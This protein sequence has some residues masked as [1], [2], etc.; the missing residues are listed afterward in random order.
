MGKTIAVSNQKGGVGKT[1]TCINLAA[2]IA[3]KG[4]K[5][6]LCDIDPQ[7][8]ATT[9]LGIEKGSLK[10]SM[11]N[12]LLGDAA[13]KDAIVP[14]A[15]ENLFILPS[16]TDLAGV[17]VELVSVRGRDKKL[18]EALESVKNAYDY[19]FI[20]CPPAIGILTVNGLT[21]CNSVLVPIQSEFFALEGVAQ[22]M[23]TFKLVKRSLNPSIEIEGV[24]ITMYDGRALVS[25]QT[26]EEIVKY[27]G[28][29]VFETVIPRNVRI[30]E[31][32]S[33][34]LPVI[35]HDKRCKGTIAYN[36]LVEEFLGR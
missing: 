2:G 32:P 19:I 7:G 24:V 5:V 33:Y 22:L 17:E 28:K 25:R 10:K 9:G 34:G 6:L 14:T 27:F 23:N 31:A 20:D 11:Y 21:A 29:K 13:A 16:N 15:I 18:R 30:S 35:L 3:L 26:R 1:S 36:A 12:V 8:N 4:K